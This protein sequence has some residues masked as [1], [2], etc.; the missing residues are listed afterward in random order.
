MIEI[1]DDMSPIEVAGALI[2]GAIEIKPGTMERV[3][4]RSAGQPEC[5]YERRFCNA[6]LA[7]IGEHLLV[8][9]KYNRE[10]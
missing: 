4:R 9:A 2:D 8:F 3:A 5:D 6:E 7:E 1:K 10:V